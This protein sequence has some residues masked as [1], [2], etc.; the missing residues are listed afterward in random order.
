MTILESPGRKRSWI[1]CISECYIGRSLCCRIPFAITQP[2][3]SGACPDRTP[4]RC[5]SGLGRHAGWHASA[6]GAAGR[7]AGNAGAGAAGGAA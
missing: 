7:A 1:Q 3:Q 5:T 4:P 6:Q 2:P